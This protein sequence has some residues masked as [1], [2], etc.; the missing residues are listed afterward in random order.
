MMRSGPTA[1]RGAAALFAAI[2]MLGML[3]ASA[4]AIDLAQLYVAKRDLQNMANLAALDVARAAGGCLAPSADRQATAN[5][6][7][8]DTLAGLGGKAEWLQGGG[9]RL[10]RALV[11]ANGLRQ[12]QSAVVEDAG[13]AY[14]F[15]LEL[16]QPMPRLI[17]PMPA[18]QD[19]GAEMRA[20]AASMMA[21]RASFSVSSFGASL[22]PTE[23]SVL[24]D[25]L[26]STLG[27][28]LSLT[29]LSPQGLLTSS[30]PLADIPEFLP[31][32]EPDELLTSP[33]EL[34]GLLTAIADVLFASGKGI[35]AAAFDTLAA[36]APNDTVILG[37][38][39]GSPD[40]FFSA[41]GGLA[42]NTLDFVQA[43]A[44]Q[45]GD[46]VIQ[47]TPGLTLPPL[48]GVGG[49]ITIGQAPSLAVGPA[50]QDSSSQFVTSARNVQGRA[51][52]GLSLDLAGLGSVNLELG[53][54]LAEATADLTAIRCAGRGRPDHEVDIGVT[55]NLARLEVNND[56]ANPLIDVL[57]LIKV[58]WEGEVELGSDAY[59]VIPFTGPFDPDNPQ[60][61]AVG[62]A[63]GATLTSALNDILVQSPPEL[64]GPLGGLNG[65][66]LVL[67]LGSEDALIGQVISQ[68]LPVLT[69]ALDDA[70][71]DPILAALGLSV[72]G[73]H[74]SVME[75]DMPPPALIRSN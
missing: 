73:A 64:C 6:T 10:G 47:L 38:V 71:L 61:Q 25:V 31:G 59:T 12:F 1:Q 44:Y 63:V 23:Q 40:D 54:D 49:I 56:E 7:A 69:T 14:A 17:L 45:V 19:G 28:P 52:L 3:I 20:N 13:E 4:F 33:I 70:L 55:T 36:A 74:V 29:A 15:E 34:P 18:Q 57:G 11:D 39:V 30:V 50:L 21:P 24:N 43:L 60:T 26:G 16:R 8:A 41:T 51:D 9:V 72:G 66:L 2:G 5:Q 42:V 35:A 68:F 46:P 58:C 62:S 27:S 65:L 67:G 22:D 75:V 37:D 53:L 32:I 48:I